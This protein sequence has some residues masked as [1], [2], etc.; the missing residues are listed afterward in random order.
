MCEISKH[1]IIGIYP[2]F[3]I[4]KLVIYNISVNSSNPPPPQKIKNKKTCPSRAKYA[5]LVSPSQITF[6]K[7]TAIRFVF[8]HLLPECPQYEMGQA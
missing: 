2:N 6:V 1:M 4:R 3:K 8:S 5:L 7:V